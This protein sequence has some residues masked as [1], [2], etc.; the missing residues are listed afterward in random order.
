MVHVYIYVH[1]Q[2][3]VKRPDLFPPVLTV[4]HRIPDQLS[5]GYIFVG[6]YETDNAGPYIYDDT[7]E[8]VWSG[9]GN[10]GPGNA[11]NVHVCQ[12]QGEDHLC[13]FQGVQQRGY[14]RG[15]GV[16][17]DRRYRIV[18]TVVP[19]G[20]M[21]SSDMHEFKLIDNGR[22]ALV[23]VYQQRAFDLSAWNVR[24]G[25]GW[26]MESVFQEVDVETG[27]VRFEWRSLD[28][29]DPSAGYTYPAHTDTSGTGLDPRSPWDYFHINSIEKNA[30][31]DYLVSA[32]HTCAVYKISGRDGSI[33]WKLHG[34]DPSFANLDFSF[35]QQH[36]A[37]WLTENATHTALSLF[38]NGWNG[39]NK[40]HDFSSGMVIVIDHVGQTAEQVHR[41]EPPPDRLTLS[42][43]QGN[44][45]TTEQGTVVVGWGNRAAI[46]EHDAEGGLLFWG[47][48][49]Q[50]PNTTS[51]TSLMN[52]RAQKFRWDGDPTD[53][54]ALWAY[55]PSLEQNSTSTTLY[56]SWNGA[57]RVR[58]WRFYGSVSQ[59]TGPYELLQ[60]VVKDGFETTCSV[61]RYV[62]WSYVE[63]VDGE[64]SVLGKSQSRFTFT[65]S[66]A[67]RGICGQG[68]C[69]NAAAF[70]V[71]GEEEDAEPFIPPTGI[72]TVPWIDP[73]HPETHFDWG[74]TGVPEGYNGYDEEDE[75]EE[76]WWLG[77]VGALVVVVGAITG[78]TLYR[79]RDRFTLLDNGSSDSLEEMEGRKSSLSSDDMAWWNGQASLQH[80]HP[81]AHRMDDG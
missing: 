22:H 48:L 9:W 67:L 3:N 63:A 21:A 26:V 55:A 11:H 76:I 52:Y 68:S 8:L 16:I 7:G 43:S 14:C 36:D 74:E 54:P 46:S 27:A 5:P 61:A 41:Y 10:S 77:V 64:G 37:R 33:L 25:I 44:M 59:H 24:T 75:V 32:R 62:R 23:T 51:T 2:G 42:S 50:P 73:D 13:F 30:E 18:K 57:T 49:G 40:T 80:Q 70:G 53:I 71:P 69:A 20:G 81:Y 78:W 31:G 65:P 17:M 4:E 56:A 47:T 6:P 58:H 66:G 45:Q 1:V 35:S 15:H 19:G 38:N 72:N 79:R 34:A 28:H 39:F 60:E 29:V 12:Y